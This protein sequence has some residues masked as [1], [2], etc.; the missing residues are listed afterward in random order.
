MR[1]QTE[2][3]QLKEIENQICRK[4]VPHPGF[5]PKISPDPGMI[6]KGTIDQNTVSAFRY[7]M[8]RM[9]TAKEMAKWITRK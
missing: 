5:L 2:L 4:R 1:E 6:P 8:G 3:L 9:P 7:E